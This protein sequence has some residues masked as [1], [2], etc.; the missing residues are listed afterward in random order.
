MK[1]QHL[2]LSAEERQALQTLLSK[3][4]LPVKQFKRATGLLAL[5]QSASYQ[6]VATLLQVTSTTVRSWRDRFVAEGMVSLQDKPRPGRPIRIDGKQRATI[7][8]LACS[9]PPT[10]YGQWSMRLLADKVVELAYC[11]A[12]SHTQVAK[13]LK[14]TR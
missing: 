11:E 5:D 3:G 12:I 14:K 2:Q 6:A 7:T 10:G 9:E 13:I 8:A 1:K 4:K